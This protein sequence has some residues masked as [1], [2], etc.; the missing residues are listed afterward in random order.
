MV[1]SPNGLLACFWL[2]VR[3]YGSADGRSLFDDFLLVNPDRARPNGVVE[4]IQNVV[5]Q[6]DPD[7]P[8]ILN[9]KSSDHV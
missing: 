4:I 8:D 3:N 6:H 1:D 7:S 5:I 2:L 9:L